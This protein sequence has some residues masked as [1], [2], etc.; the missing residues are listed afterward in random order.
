MRLAIVGAGAIGGIARRQSDRAPARRSRSSPGARPCGPSASVGSRI[1]TPERRFVVHPSLEPTNMQRRDRGGRGLPRREGP[2]STSARPAARRGASVPTR[3]P[4]VSSRTASPGGTSRPSSGPSP[5]LGSRVSTR[6]G[7]SRSTCRR[8]GCAVGSRRLPGGTGRRLLGSRAHLEGIAS[9]SGSPTARR[10]ERCTGRS[11]PR[12]PAGVRLQPP[13]GRDLRGELWL[14]LVGHRRASTPLSSANPGEPRC[15]HLRPARPAARAPRHG[16]G[17]GGGRLGRRHTRTVDRSASR[18]CGEV[19]EHRTSMLQDLE[20]GRHLELEPILGAV[21]EIGR[22]TGVGTPTLDILL[23]CTGLLAGPLRDLRTEV[24]SSVDELAELRDERRHSLVPGR[25]GRDLQLRHAG[26][27]EGRY[28]LGH[29]RGRPAERHA[30]QQLIRYQSLGFGLLAR[31]IEIL[32]L[33]SLARSRIGRRR[34]CRSSGPWLPYRRYR[35][36]A[37]A[38]ATPSLDGLRE[39]RRSRGGRPRRSA[40]SRGSARAWPVLP[41]GRGP[42][43]GP[44]SRE[45]TESEAIRPQPPRSSP[46]SS[47][48]ARRPRSGCGGGPA[49]R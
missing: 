43:P 49:G 25:D 35:A 29:E 42:T 1:I 7:L 3:C 47:R 27:F 28:P 16:R 2:R 48:R 14:K 39:R 4:R 40:R 5:T 32:D 30:R 41:P 19:G 36:R 45:R 20:A 23:A 8:P 9:R 13:V 12:P 33:G 34:R 31:Q 18:S 44:P 10:S 22:L 21:V 38:G 17:R 37:S 46:R 26:V 11:P 15:P 24:P 6:A